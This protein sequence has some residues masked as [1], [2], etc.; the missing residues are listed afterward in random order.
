MELT[1]CVLIGNKERIATKTIIEMEG[2]PKIKIDLTFVDKASEIIGWLAVL[3]VWILTIVN[4][5]NLPDSIPTHYNAAGKI[6][7]FGSKST[8][9]LLPAVATVLFII[10][11]ILNRF[12]HIFNYPTTITEKNALKQYTNATRLIRYLKFI[13][14][15][16]L[17]LLVFKTIGN[18][19]G[20]LEGLGAWFSYV[21]LGA[22][23]IPVFL[24]VIN[25]SRR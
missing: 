8:I 7:G 25:S 11:T 13:I 20:Q 17:G 24:F 9:W 16:V 6:D 18:A 21:V 12:P 15:V 14:V 22:M 4:Y 2:R 10:M 5:S 3:A 23:L 1:V 19:N